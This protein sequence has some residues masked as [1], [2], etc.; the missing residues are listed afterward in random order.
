MY[1][2]VFPGLGLG[3]AGVVEPGRRAGAGAGRGHGLKF[4]DVAAGPAH[5]VI[6]S[7]PT[8]IGWERADGRRDRNQNK[9]NSKK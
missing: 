6:N 1:C 4:V 7:L 9:N 3:G 5:V 2:R 8:K